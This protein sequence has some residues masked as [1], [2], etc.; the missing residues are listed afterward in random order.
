MDRINRKHF[1][2]IELLVVIAIIAIL[3][4][5]LLPALNK[6]R[7]TARKASCISNLK[8]LGLAN[9][10]YETDNEGFVPGA[11]TAD[12]NLANGWNAWPQMLC[13]GEPPFPNENQAANYGI[14]NYVDWKVTYCP[15]MAGTSRSR[16]ACYGAEY[17][18]T[19]KE[20][21]E[22]GNFI[23]SDYHHNVKQIKNAAAAIAYAEVSRQNNLTCSNVVF[24]GGATGQNGVLTFERHSGHAPIVFHDGHAE[25]V[26]EETMIAA[27]YEFTKYWD[28]NRI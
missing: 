17:A 21:S 13:N 22:L 4:G 2:L 9:G 23:T 24:A 11:W 5:M 7:A 18:L 1:T 15:I 16:N 3:A 12:G 20:I 28:K 27:P 19:A 8:Q 26:T 25:A 14:G 6:A 10:M